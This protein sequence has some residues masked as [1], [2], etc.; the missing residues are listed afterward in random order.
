MRVAIVFTV[1]PATP[2]EIEAVEPA[3]LWSG[4]DVPKSAE[5]P[6]LQEVR[7]SVIKRYEPEK[8][9]YRFLHGVALCF[10]KDRLYASVGHNKG[11]ENTD[12]EEARYSMSDDDGQ[13]WS[14]MKTIDAGTEPGI[15]VS[16]GVFLSHQGQLWAFH[17]AYRDTRQETHTRAY[18]LDEASQVWKVQGTIIQAPWRAPWSQT[19]F[20]VYLSGRWDLKI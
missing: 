10:H 5:I 3:G 18:V 16:H 12:T 13:T 2:H 8:D 19:S 7:F 11:V 14:A 1:L 17:G 6:V 9:G 15:G 4:G 20:F